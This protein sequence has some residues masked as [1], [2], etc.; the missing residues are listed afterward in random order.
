MEIVAQTVK[1]MCEGRW[2]GP[3]WFINAN[4]HFSGAS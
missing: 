2:I 1:Q 3:L 4:R